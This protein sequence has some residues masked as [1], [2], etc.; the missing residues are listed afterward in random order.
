MDVL[1]NEDQRVLLHNILERDLLLSLMLD[2]RDSFMDGVA[3]VKQV[4]EGLCNIFMRRVEF[5]KER[6]QPGEANSAFCRRLGHLGKLANIREVSGNDLLMIRFTACCEDD[7][8]RRDIFKIKDLTWDSLVEAVRSHEAASRMD[9]V[10]KTRD[11]LFKM[12]VSG[13]GTTADPPS[14][15]SKTPSASPAPNPFSKVHHKQDKKGQDWIDERSKERAKHVDAIRKAGDFRDSRGHFERPP[16]SKSREHVTCHRCQCQGHFASS[17]TAPAPVS[18]P[19]SREPQGSSGRRSREASWDRNR[20]ASGDRHRG[21]SSGSRPSREVNRRATP[22]GS[23]DSSQGGN[24][25]LHHLVYYAGVD[26][27]SSDGEE[28][29]GDEDMEESVSFE[30][31]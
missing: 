19:A 21:G 5:M 12:S 15:T 23:R 13:T 26:V 24:H 30:N 7:A 1:K 14:G 16:R 27:D 10:T 8:L 31:I 9:T 20:T 25:S 28:D 4:F 29:E 18:R 22:Y 11:K 2:E 6:K 3:K 17:C